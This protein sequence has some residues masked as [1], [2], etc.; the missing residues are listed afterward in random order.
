MNTLNTIQYNTTQMKSPFKGLPNIGNSCYINGML[1]CIFSFDFIIRLLFEEKYKTHMKDSI[2]EKDLIFIESFKEL[3]SKY[4]HKGYE[5]KKVYLKI[6]KSALALLNPEFKSTNQQ[7]SHEFLIIFLD[8]IQRNLI[9]VE[10]VREY[11]K[12]LYVDS[13][14][15]YNLN[16]TYL[17]EF[18]ANQILSTIVC[19]SCGKEVSYSFETTFINILSLPP[20]RES[21]IEECF[22]KWSGG[23]ILQDYKCNNCGLFNT[24]LKNN[25]F[26]RIPKCMI[27]QLKRPVDS[28]GNLIKN[29]IKIKEE[30]NINKYKK[31]TKADVRYDLFAINYHIGPT[32]NSGHYYSLI[33]GKGAGNERGNWVMCDDEII[34][35][36]DN[37]EYYLDSKD[38]YILFYFKK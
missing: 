14:T 10:K 29:K 16:N 31:H 28:K 1:Q 20:N 26:F 23:D 36:I 37:P 3:V 18:L 9:K 17:N 21:T 13:L 33:K 32:A 8:C 6:F 35:T 22:D 7:D 30:L 19:I 38:S 4:F 24:C 15:N 34:E 2:K 11:T 27:I 25:L 12:Q 5:I